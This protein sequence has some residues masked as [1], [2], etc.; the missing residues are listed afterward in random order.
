MNVTPRVRPA[1]RWFGRTDLF[2]LLGLTVALF[3]VI[4]QPV[5]TLLDYVREIEDTRDLRLLPALMILATVFI[6]HQ[7]WKRQEMRAE[8]LSAAAVARQAT[9]RA[10]ELERLVALGQALA[11]TLD[12]ETIRAA[13]AEHLPMLAPGREGW[14]MLK[15]GTTWRTLTV[16]GDTP[17]EKRERAARLALEES[18][19]GPSTDDV[20]F[21]M[22]VAGS[23]IGVL[24]VSPYPALTDHQRSMLAAAAALL[25]VS[26]KNADL[27]REV[28]ESSL[29]DA[30]TGCFNRTHAI[31]V[32][33][34]E[35]RR[36]SRSLMPVSLLMFDLDHFKAINDN[37]GH[38]CGDAV[39]AAIGAR[40]R[41]VLRGSDMK[42][43][44]G[45]EEFLVLL[46]DTPIGG[47]Q[48][49][50]ENLRRDI[51]KTPVRWKDRI[52][53]VTA[54]FGVTEVVPGEIDP[55][56]VMSR[57]DGALYVAKQQG[58]N[59]VRVSEPRDLLLLKS[60]N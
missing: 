40:M 7:L 59:C 48:R 16:V 27:F 18:T 49:V 10:A 56:A 3:V 6:C 11:R 43:R 54:S 24:G 51:E 29:R 58:R 46:P 37:Y 52:V 26:I 5:A 20:C 17:V 8:A 53:P 13:I 32:I 2:L 23:P 39:L 22:V 33:D 55:L 35:L 47:A 45:G 9:V 12:H 41:T 19:P 4:S 38:L 57:A 31:E 44:Y 28:H 14:A 34:A 1:M 15:T 30:L 21:P 50:A 36:A 42:C 25:A 60:A